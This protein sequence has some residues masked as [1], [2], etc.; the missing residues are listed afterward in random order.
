M[1]RPQSNTNIDA[2]SPATRGVGAAL[3]DARLRRNHSIADVSAHLRIRAPVLEAMEAGRFEKLPNGAYAL[4][5]VRSYADFL[6]LDR[7]EVAR[8]VKEEAAALNAPPELVFPSPLT[9]SRLPSGLVMLLSVCLA[10]GAYGLWYYNTSKEGGA[11]RVDAAPGAFNPVAT[12]PTTNSSVQA[13]AATVPAPQPG[14]LQAPG[15]QQA[16]APAAD[17]VAQNAA[18]VPVAP[19][20][21][22]TQAAPPAPVAPP[23]Q[24]ASV[25]AAATIV[26]ADTGPK[27]YGGEANPRIVI[28]ATGDSWVQVRDAAGAIVFSRILRPG[29]SYAA[30]NQSGYQLETG[31]AGVLD[32]MVDGRKAPALGRP[33]FIRR[34]VPLDPVKLA[35]GVSEAAAPPRPAPVEAA[36][37]PAVQAP[38]ASEAPAAAPAE[39]ASEN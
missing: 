35:A 1:A 32:V 30:P 34:D 24:T 3:R 22:Q 31:S 8:R 10:G 2:P 17:T 18:P 13:E 29:E 20:Q 38:A 9:E 12:R 5:F 25:P 36:P 7:D 15:A 33:G 14:A 19:P 37:P 28:R 16:Q 27:Q 6:G 11:P 26:P 21:V 23:P 39:P 4:G